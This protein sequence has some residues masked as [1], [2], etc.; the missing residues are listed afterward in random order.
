MKI[1]LHYVNNYSIYIIPAIIILG[2]IYSAFSKS[3]RKAVYK[4]IADAES[5][6]TP[7]KAVYNIMDKI[8]RSD[9]DERMVEV[10]ATILCNVPLLR[11]I[12]RP[13]IVNVLNNYVQKSFNNVK[14]LLDAN[15]GKAEKAQDDLIIDSIS[16][17]ISKKA[18]EIISKLEEK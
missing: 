18:D 4:Y 12:P 2:A 7:R 11:I 5:S 13:I 15:K 14:V 1:L 16:G 3:A 8:Q 17:I 10:I 6:K 9:L